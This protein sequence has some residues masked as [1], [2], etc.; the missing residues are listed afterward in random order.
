MS[1][2]CNAAR[3]EIFHVMSVLDS[4]IQRKLRYKSSDDTQPVHILFITD[5]IEM[6]KQHAIFMF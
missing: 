2:T 4:F 1:E 3:C 5:L 6:L